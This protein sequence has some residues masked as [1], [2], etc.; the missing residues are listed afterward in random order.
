MICIPD[1][2]KASEALSNE[3]L[4]AVD[5][6][7]SVCVNELKERTKLCSD[8]KKNEREKSKPDKE[9]QTKSEYKKETT[10]RERDDKKEWRD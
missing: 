8:N 7:S 1:N 6:L 3:S 10:E 2:V 5:S 4:G 9:Q